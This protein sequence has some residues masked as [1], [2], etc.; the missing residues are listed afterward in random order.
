MLFLLSNVEATLPNCR[1]TLKPKLPSSYSKGLEW[2][3]AKSCGMVKRFWI[4]R[5]GE[6][7]IRSQVPKS[8]STIRGVAFP[9]R[10]K[11][12]EDMGKVQRLY[13]SASERL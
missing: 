11:V 1:N 6:W 13:G 7:A 9:A 3:R 10:E 2:H 12:G 8:V 5:K 4:I